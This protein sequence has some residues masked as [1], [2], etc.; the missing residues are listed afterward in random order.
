MKTLDDKINI[1]VEDIM[2][3]EGLNVNRH[4]KNTKKN[5]V[6]ALLTGKLD[7][8]TVVMIMISLEKEINDE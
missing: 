4:T 8:Q 6:Q 5:Y 2:N 7:E 3:I 1:L